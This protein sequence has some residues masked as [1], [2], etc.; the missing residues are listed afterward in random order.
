MLR[1]DRPPAALVG[2]LRAARSG[3][4]SSTTLAV[5][6]MRR[7]NLVHVNG[8]AETDTMALACLAQ[9]GLVRCSTPALRG[10][11]G[12]CSYWFIADS[13]ARLRMNERASVFT[14][15]TNPG[16]RPECGSVLAVSVHGVVF[17]RRGG[18]EPRTF[19]GWHDVRRFE[20]AMPHGLRR[21]WWSA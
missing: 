10:H 4:G 15:R 13:K 12:A 7:R 18:P 1:A 21:W 8:R 16:V 5:Y 20:V 11:V 14:C 2:T 17:T 9:F 19:C 3:G 6:P